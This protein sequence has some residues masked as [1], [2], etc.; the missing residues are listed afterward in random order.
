[1]HDESKYL[2]SRMPMEVLGGYIPTHAILSILHTV[3]G[4][5]KNVLRQVPR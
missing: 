1:M 2:K 5:N 4:D 3:S